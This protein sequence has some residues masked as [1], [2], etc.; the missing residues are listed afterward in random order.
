LSVV[1][2]AVVLAVLVV[3][4]GAVG[5]DEHPALSSGSTEAPAA[6]PPASPT[7]SSSS[8]GPAVPTAAVVLYDQY[9]NP[10]AQ[11]VTSQNF[12]AAYDAYDD[13]AADGTTGCPSRRTSP[14]PQR[15]VVLAQPERAGEHCGSLAEPGRRLRHPRLR[16]LGRPRGDVRPLIREPDQMFRLDGTVGVPGGSV[17]WAMRFNGAGNGNDGALAVA[18]S[19]GGSKVFVTGASAGSG[20]GDDYATIAHSAG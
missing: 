7:T 16:Q 19:P 3:P 1:R 13:E 17:L 9:E 12:E 10:A 2:A 11:D 20:S 8:A 15:T 18:V 5:A 4:Q 14:S 6:S